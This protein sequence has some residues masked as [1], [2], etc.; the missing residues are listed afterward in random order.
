M[1]QSKWSSDEQALF[2]ALQSLMV[3]RFAQLNASA[4]R[5]VFDEVLAERKR[6]LEHES[7]LERESSGGWT[8]RIEKGVV[9]PVASTHQ[10]G[11]VRA[12]VEIVAESD[13]LIDSLL[14][15][16]LEV[17][18]VLVQLEEPPGLNDIVQVKLSFPRAHLEVEARARVVHQSSR[19]TAIEVSGLSREDRVALQAI[20]DDRRRQIEEQVAEE[21]GPSVHDSFQDYHSI[22]PVPVADDP[23]RSFAPYGSRRSGVKRTMQ[24]TGRRRFDMPDPDMDVVRSTLQSMKSGL[25]TREF[26]GPAPTWFDPDGDPDRVEE[27]AGERVLDILLQLSAS[28]FTGAVVH[29]HEEASRQMLFESGYVV[30]IS[31]QPRIPGSE[32][33]PMLEAASRIT[34]RQLAMA[35]AHADEMGTTLARSLMELDILDPERIRHAISGRLTFLLREFCDEREGSLQVFDSSSLPADFLPQPPL[36]VHAA[37]ERIIYDRLMRGLSQCSAKEREQVMAPELDAYPEVLVQERDRL[38][39][40]VSAAPQIR[41][42][43]KVL[44]GRR[45]L[46]EVLT[47]SALAPAE[48]FAVVFSLHR[49]GLL[50]FDR[51]LHQTVVRERLRENV[52][53]K[54]LS[55]HKASYFE[56]LNVHWSSYSEVIEKAYRELKEQFDPSRVPTELE[57]EVHQ[58][59]G[60]INERVEAAFAALAKRPTRHGYRTRIMPE[61]KLAHAVPLF[62]KQSE[63]AER[64]GQWAEARDAAR[65]VLEIEP[66]NAEGQRRLARYEKIIEQGISPDPADT[67]Q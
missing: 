20:A 61:Y 67:N 27:L 44:N 39:R 16:I 47:E 30:E 7:A 32:L 40:A 19:G 56:V 26:Y 15:Q 43:D 24:T 14:H 33:G 54:Y 22:P 11:R 45:R 6:V 63:L 21:E 41:L 2:N 1:S 4:A 23:M 66:E 62:L 18:A 31:S 8:G 38:E 55:V 59:V 64:R 13:D 34:K 58:R 48:T 53:V 49:M 36:R 5:A 57:E 10:G 42:V 52:T 17:G 12:D 35:A 50:H 3:E 37:V 51:S 60:E 9:S 29:R 28:G 65:R 25:A 46:R